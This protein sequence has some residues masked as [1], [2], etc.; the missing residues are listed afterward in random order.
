MHS[1]GQIL[2]SPRATDAH[3]RGAIDPDNKIAWDDHSGPMII[4]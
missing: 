4:A 3:S 2:E 1:I